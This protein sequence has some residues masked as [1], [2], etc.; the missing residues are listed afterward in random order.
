[1]GTQLW[2]SSSSSTFIKQWINDGYNHCRQ[3]SQEARLD[4]WYQWS[5]NPLLVDTHNPTGEDSE[6]RL[7]SMSFSL[8]ININISNNVVDRKRLHWSLDEQGI[9]GTRI[10]QGR[11]KYVTMSWTYIII[12]TS[13]GWKR[14]Q[15]ALECPINPRRCSTSPCTLNKLCTTLTYQLQFYRWY[16]GC[17]TRPTATTVGLSPWHTQLFPSGWTTLTAIVVPTTVT[18]RLPTWFCTIG[19]LCY[20]PTLS[21]IRIRILSQ[22]IPSSIPI[23]L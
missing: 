15:N 10:T 12:Y 16:D 22:Q 7:L 9:N 1:M 18:L 14:V 4:R 2:S 6:T 19:R 3:F 8:S 11:V 5:A 13:E 23:K 20:R 21:Q 17:S